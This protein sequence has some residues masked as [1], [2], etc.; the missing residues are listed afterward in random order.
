MVGTSRETL[1]ELLRK[2]GQE[3]VLQFWD[4]LSESQRDALTQ[5]IASLDFEQLDKLH[6]GPGSQEDWGALADSATP[7]PA[8]RLDGSKNRFTADEAHAAADEALKSGQV[9][10]ILVAGG[11]GTRLGFPHPKGMFPVGPVT[12][13]TLFQFFAD[14]LLALGR[15]YG[16]RV[17]LFLMTSPATHDET[18]AYFQEHD[19]LGLA[20]EDLHIFCQGTMPA[21]DDQG[22]LLLAE[23]DRI[24]LSPD[25]HGGMLAALAKSGGLAAAKGRGISQFFY[26]QV[27]NPLVTIGDRTLLGYHL[28]ANSE[29]STLVVAKTDPTER[30]GNVV[31]VDGRLHVIEYSDLPLSSAERRNADGSLALWAGSIAVHVLSAEFLQRAA[32]SAESLP[33]HLARKQVPYVDA[34]GNQ[35]QPE[36]PNAT[37]FE[38][39]IFDL[40][41][42]ARNA[43]VVEGDPTEVFAPVKNASGAEKDTPELAR[44]AIVDRAKR[45]LAAAGVGVA[46][47]VRVELSPFTALDV[48]S[49][50]SRSL[51]K[52]IVTD[53]YVECE[54]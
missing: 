52:Q 21:L 44:Q 19:N 45:W 1:V 5:Q 35:V 10:A 26:F 9:G 43:I 40:M 8:F 17:P 18:V 20:A 11:Q 6:R 54:S 25:G 12:E 50:K 3:H 48:Q 29:M 37:K 49:L 38:R 16:V 41:P 51:P 15:R 36:Q 22:R 24:F 4:E 53:L 39:F 7:P 28:L 27:D 42:E 47:G 33:F 14:Q 13:R 32:G 31:S 2:Y 30:V 46:D 34:S 23:R